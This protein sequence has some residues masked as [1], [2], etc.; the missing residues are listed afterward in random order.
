MNQPK[1][2][3]GQV[4]SVPPGVFI[5]YNPGTGTQTG[6]RSANQ[7]RGSGSATGKSAYDLLEAAA[8]RRV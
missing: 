7:N 3:L 1:F 2:K 6:Y 4:V 5:V 8:T